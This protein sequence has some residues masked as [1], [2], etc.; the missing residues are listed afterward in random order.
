M[1]W[2]VVLLVLA[3]LLS[4]RKALA[5]FIGGQPVTIAGTTI[6]T[7]AGETLYMESDAAAAF[8]RMKEAA[9]AVGVALVPTGARA[10]F[11]THEDQEFLAETRSSFAAPVDRSPHQAGIAIDLTTASGTNAAFRWLTAN[12]ARFNFKRTRADEPWHWEYRP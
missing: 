4:S 7:I 6:G 8:L 11:R 2:I 10:A 12:A 1:Q 9:T 5:G 3:V